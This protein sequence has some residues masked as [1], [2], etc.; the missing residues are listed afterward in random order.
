MA[1]I[2]TKTIQ[3]INDLKKGNQIVPGYVVKTGKVCVFDLCD[4]TRISKKDDWV[5]IKSLVGSKRLKSPSK[6]DWK[7]VI[8]IRE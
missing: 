2:Y 1:I 4:V 3:D 8:E 5:D 6:H 7:L